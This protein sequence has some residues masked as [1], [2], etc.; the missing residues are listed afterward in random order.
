MNIK[1]KILKFYEPMELDK[2]HRYRSWEHCYSYFSGQDVDI[3]YAC[4]HL[5]FYLASWGM[6]RGSSDLLQKDYLVHRDVVSQLIANRHL[7]SASF[8]QDKAESISEVF[9]LIEFIRKHYQKAMKMVRGRKREKPFIATDTLVTKILLGTLGCI[10]AY[11][12]FFID[13]MRISGIPYSSLSKSN[14]DKVIQ[15][16]LDNQREVDQA[17]EVITIKSGVQYPPMKLVDMYFWSVGNP[18]FN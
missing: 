12:R 18:E 7:M 5:A 6:Y 11:D 14:F 8:I 10:P 4:L 1:S 13:G 2:N 15:F 17:R 16:Y 9:E 3:E